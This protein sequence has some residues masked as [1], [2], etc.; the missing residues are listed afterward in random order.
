MNIPKSLMAILLA[1][2]LTISAASVSHATYAAETRVGADI[3]TTADP[4]AETEPTEEATEKVPSEESAPTDEVNAPVDSAEP[5]AI[6]APSEDQNKTVAPPMPD[7]L[8]ANYNAALKTIINLNKVE[9][10]GA[11]ISNVDAKISKFKDLLEIEYAIYEVKGFAPIIN[12]GDS[13]I[14][15]HATSNGQGTSGSNIDDWAM[16]NEG[17]TARVQLITALATKNG[18]LDQSKLTT[19]QSKTF[20]E[21]IQLGENDSRYNEYTV[22]DASQKADTVTQDNPEAE[23]SIAFTNTV[24]SCK[25]LYDAGVAALNKFLPAVGAPITGINN[26]NGESLAKLATNVPEYNSYG[27]FA[28]NY[29]SFLDLYDA[30]EDHYWQLFYSYVSAA[31][32]WFENQGKEVSSYNTDALTVSYGRVVTAAKAIDP[33]FEVDLSQVSALKTLPTLPNTGSLQDGE[34]SASMIAL[35][36]GGIAATV[37]LAGLGL[38]IKRFC[39]SPLKHRR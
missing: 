26:M 28:A 32:T 20:L 15:P 5:T 22:T 35:A 36:L 23:E 19:L 31:I 2:A 4:K 27:F 29:I 12:L 21:L 7:A 1:T 17:E 25:S 37:T 14:D 39:F 18:N 16:V 10:V 8:K 34:N 11:A 6:Q 38:T 3:V 13:T 24:N 9:A 33:K 30:I